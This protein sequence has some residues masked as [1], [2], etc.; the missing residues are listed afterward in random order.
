MQNLSAYCEERKKIKQ[1]RKLKKKVIQSE[2][3]KQARKG[4]IFTI[5]N[6]T[7]AAHG[8]KNKEKWHH[9]YSSCFR[10]VS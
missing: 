10:R 7:K 4:D 5:R 3:K 6:I 2:I 8:L 9:T 1:N